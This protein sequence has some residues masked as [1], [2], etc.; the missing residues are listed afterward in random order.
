MS[1][2]RLLILAAALE[3]LTG[4]ALVVI[5]EAVVRLLLGEDLSRV[6]LA[7]ARVAGIGLLS[8]G[9]ACLPGSAMS[10][11]RSLQAMLCY[12]GLTTAY[13]IYLG[14][15]GGLGGTLLWPAVAIHVVLTVLFARAC[16]PV[17]K[18]SE[19]LGRTS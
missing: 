11:D 14:V 4:I 8:L 10:V 6:G 2:R 18:R 3:L 7:L 13:L 5:P 16:W 9:L 15:A 12:N 1:A 17:S 19:P